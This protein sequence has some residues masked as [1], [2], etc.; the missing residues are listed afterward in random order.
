MASTFELYYTFVLSCFLYKILW[1]ASGRKT[2]TSWVV[3]QTQSLT[4]IPPC[5][6]TWPVEL[7]T[8]SSLVRL[9]MLIGMAS[10]REV[11]TVDWSGRM[12]L[13]VVFKAGSANLMSPSQAYQ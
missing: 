7:K 4:Q 11:T 9:P 8:C 2:H 3:G 12:T 6:P 10:Y 13:L 1:L 5:L